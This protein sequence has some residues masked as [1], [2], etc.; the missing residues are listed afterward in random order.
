MDIAPAGLDRMV[1]SIGSAFLPSHYATALGNMFRHKG[2][3]LMTQ[4][5]L[6]AAGASFL[7]VMSLNTSLALTLDN[8]FARQRYDITIGFDRDQRGDRVITL[9][10][11]GAWRGES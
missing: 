2:R 7:M 9:G 8:Y 6:I 5:V 11:I 10:R 1:E 4:L 3:L